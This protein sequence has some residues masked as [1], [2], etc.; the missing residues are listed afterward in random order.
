MDYDFKVKLTG[1]RERVEDLFEYE[2]CKVGRG[3]YGH[4]Y[5]AKRKDGWVDEQQ[6]LLAS[7]P[8][9]SLPPASCLSSHLPNKCYLSPLPPPFKATCRCGSVAVGL[10]R[11]KREPCEQFQLA[12]L[13]CWWSFVSRTKNTDI[14]FTTG[15]G[16]FP[17]HASVL[18][19]ICLTLGTILFK[20]KYFLMPSPMWCCKCN[21]AGACGS[22]CWCLLLFCLSYTWSTWLQRDLYK[23]L[24]ESKK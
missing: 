21:T 14:R 7:E 18:S 6:G 13:G 3:T 20:L 22:T 24:C 8:L 12:L 10:C 2:G 16:A 19:L 9:A 17:F 5:K 15:I 1:E 4:V 23:I 11:D